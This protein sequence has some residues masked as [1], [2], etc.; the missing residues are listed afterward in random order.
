MNIVGS[1]IS[2]L[3]QLSYRVSVV[4]VKPASLSF[5]ERNY[6]LSDEYVSLVGWGITHDSPGQPSRYLHEVKVKVLPNAAC[7][8]LF[9]NLLKQKL[10]I[11]EKF[12]CTKGQPDAFLANVSNVC[13]T[14]I[15][16]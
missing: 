16:R 9:K 4:T 5:I 7:E 14:S 3:L 12:L 11:H 15:Y 10:S 13:L 2:L 1:C 8:L 6:D